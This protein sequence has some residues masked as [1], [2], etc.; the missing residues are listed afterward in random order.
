M[1]SGSVPQ[2]MPITT[3]SVT[4]RKDGRAHDV[5]DAELASGAMEGNGYFLAVCGH[6]VA[7]APMVEPGGKR[8]GLC[9]E[10]GDLQTARKR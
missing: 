5:P 9:A 3:V 10:V 1:A 6:L 7:A 8:C 2:P 4:C